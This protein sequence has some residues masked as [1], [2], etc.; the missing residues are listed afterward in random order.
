[1]I[2]ADE[3]TGNLDRKTG[4]EIIELLREV[5][6]QHA[7]TVICATHDEKMLA[8]SDRVLHMA[9]GCLSEEQHAH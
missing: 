5:N 6:R 1:L 9:D 2:L 4:A 3:P 7:V 8:V